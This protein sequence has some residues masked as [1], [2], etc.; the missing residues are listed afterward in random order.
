MPVNP[1][2]KG[3][4]DVPVIDG[5]TGASTAA[6]ARIN[7]DTM[8][9]AEHDLLD[10]SGLTGVGDLFI[11]SHAVL[12]HSTIPMSLLNVGSATSAV[13]TGDLAAGNGT[14][15]LFFDASTGDFTVTGGSAAN[16]FQYRESDGLVIQS[17]EDTF[18]NIPVGGFS[19]NSF[20]TGTATVG[21]GTRYSWNAESAGGTNRTMMVVSTVYTDA[22]DTTEDADAVFG[23]LQNGVDSVEALRIRGADLVTAVAGGIE[24]GSAPSTTAADGDIIAGNGTEELRWDS[25]LTQLMITGNDAIGAQGSLHIADNDANMVI[26]SFS[27]T[28]T[29]SASIT[30]THARGTV[31]VGSDTVASDTLGRVIGSGWA[32]G[33][34]AASSEV[35]FENDGVF[36]PSIDS[37]GRLKLMTTSPS[38][39][40]TTSSKWEIN[41]SGHL[42]ARGTGDNTLDIGSEDGGT[43][44]FRPRTVYVGTSLEVGTTTGSSAAGDIQAGDGTFEMIYNAS[45]GTLALTG[46]SVAGDAYNATANMNARVSNRLSNTNSGAS[47]SAQHQVSADVASIQMVATSSTA[48]LPNEGIFSITGGPATF[49]TFTAGEPVRI[50]VAGTK[51]WRFHQDGHFVA[52]ITDNLLD[53]GSQDGG[54]TPNRPRTIYVGTSIVGASQATT[55]SILGTT[56]TTAATAGAAVTILGGD[57]LTTGAGGALRVDAGN[58]PS[59]T[60]G[61]LLIGDVNAVSVSVGRTGQNTQVVGTLGA[62]QATTF[63]AVADFD[64]GATVAAGQSITGDGALTV[65]ATSAVLSLDG[66]GI[67]TSATTFTADAGLSIATTTTGVLTLDSGTTGAVN[68]ATGASAKTISIGN[69]TGTTAVNIDYGTGDLTVDGQSDILLSAVTGI[70]IFASNT[71]ASNFT[72]ANTTAS[73]NTALTILCD[74]T[75]A[76]AGD[77]TLNLN[78][79]STNGSAIINIGSTGGLLGFYGATAVVQSA[80]YTPTNVVTDRAYD[81]NATSLNEVADVLG[82]L[83]ADLQATGI[84]G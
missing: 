82:T 53:W 26:Q 71:T 27:A 57:G 47:A 65:V 79:T 16:F 22:T 64:A 8:D 11:A 37:R 48:T 84:I 9:E 44:P 74:N 25:S 62:T 75:G 7:L 59:G 13:A 55:F 28:A 14:Q 2:I 83:I 23:L 56:A 6:Q 38:V 69:Q 18:N 77:A 36:T 21:F 54:T 39:W 45:A 67:E 46:W 24:V 30:L 63:T 1:F 49:G 76:T 68:L 42:T 51:R 12:D 40:A 4:T 10:H 32:S 72:S 33:A 80:A 52:D 3:G 81:A 66:T 41:S 60:N 70:S 20:T 35:R 5:G 58:S 73:T 15:E 34:N 31:A 61:A 78:A 17:Y 43:T 50:L 19:A 29:A